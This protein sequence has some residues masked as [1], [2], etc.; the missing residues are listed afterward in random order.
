MADQEKPT[1]FVIQRFDDGGTYDKRYAETIHPALSTAG[2]KPVRSDQM[3]GLQPVI[4]KIEKAIRDADICVAE[5]STDNPNV[6]LELGYALALQQ[7]V[8]ILCD[9]SVRER[10]P[11]DIQHR[12][13]ILYRADSKSG[14]E[15]LE[16][17]LVL[18]VSN[19]LATRTR[20]AANRVRQAGARD[21]GDMKSY[22][23]AL[24][25]TL[26][27]MWPSSPDGAFGYDL[28]KA[29]ASLGIDPV[30]IGFGL[31]RLLEKGYVA[32]VVQHDMDREW[33]LYQ[34]TPAGIAWLHDNEERVEQTPKA[35][36]TAPKQTPS[37]FD[38]DD[39]PF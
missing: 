5:V 6:W 1:C 21:I 15:D 4:E 25:S 17:R 19:Q 13:V 37:T 18:E 38:E 8:V 23:V 24:L 22:E 32:K 26:L 14:F 28:E 33:L 31:T 9:R 30:S 20:L 27:A 34:L 7:P 2:V 3:L 12:P 36:V 39:I 16:K 35:P 10:L 29:L 11:F